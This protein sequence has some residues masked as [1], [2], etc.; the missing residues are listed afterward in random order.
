MK[1]MRGGK[2]INKGAYGC[3]YDPPLICRG[4]TAPIGGWNSGRLGKLTAKIDVKGEITAA[5]LF[6]NKPE[7]NKYLLLPLLDTLC[8]PGPNGEPAIV[9]S[10]QR[11]KEFKDCNALQEHGIN[12]ML[13]F[14]VEYGGKDQGNK[15]DDLNIAIRS[16]FSLIKYM[17]EVLE[18][19]AFICL[20]GFIHNDL[21]HGNLLL[22]KEFHPRLIDYGRS[23]TQVITPETFEQLGIMSYEPHLGQVTPECAVKDGILNDIGLKKIFSDIFLS[24]DPSKQ[25]PGLLYA[26]RLFNQSREKEMAE[27]E[28]FWK[29]SKSAQSKD[30]VQFLKLYWHV[31]DSWSIGHLLISL[32]LKMLQQTDFGDTETFNTN[33]DR[34]QIVICGLLKASPIKRLDCVEALS[35]FNPKNKL[36]NS[37]S[38]KK[39]LQRRKIQ[40]EKT[41]K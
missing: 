15:L 29:T 8:K 40:R 16:G 26:E 25:K 23:Y 35:L 34:F 28:L 33:F 41:P 2:M 17:E 10:E 21:H 18:V 39:W 20:N 38:G 24:M 13:H 3:I 1:P 6:R 14:Q 36:V 5:E 9:E 30:W 27:F 22:N 31:N 37:P 11:E 12:E 19:G 4:Q 7:A 32:L